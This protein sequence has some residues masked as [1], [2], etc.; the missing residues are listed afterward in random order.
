LN[1]SSQPIFHFKMSVDV[2]D[3]LPDFYAFGVAPDPPESYNQMHPGTYSKPGLPQWYRFFRPIDSILESFSPTHQVQGTYPLG[4]YSITTKADQVPNE[5][6]SNNGHDS[7]DNGSVVDT[8]ASLD[9]VTACFNSITHDAPASGPSDHANSSDDV[10]VCDEQYPEGDAIHDDAHTFDG[11]LSQSSRNSNEGD[12]EDE[13][14]SDE[15][16]L[17]SSPPVHDKSA[18]SDGT[19]SEVSLGAE[20]SVYKESG[21]FE[22][23]RSEVS[24]DAEGSVY[25]ESDIGGDAHSESNHES[26]ETTHLPATSLPSSPPVHDKSAYSDG[27]RSEVSLGAEESVYKES[28]NFEDARSEV[29]LDAEGSVYRESDIGGDAHSESNHES[30]ETTHLPAT[31]LPSSLPAQGGMSK[32][33]DSFTDIC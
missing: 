21:N 9:S 6:T 1:A 3:E 20:E 13:H 28:G 2:S 23:A 16:G 7:V 5:L 24:L 33:L 4:I 14:Q 10:H 18:Y 30:D 15:N 11:T 32:A 17:P 19:R 12:S 31:S 8:R 27:T 25:R 29:S 26:D 22:D